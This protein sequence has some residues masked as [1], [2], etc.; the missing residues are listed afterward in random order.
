MYRF[1]GA[2][3]SLPVDRPHS[4]HV[5]SPHMS[6]S[7]SPQGRRSGEDDLA[8]SRKS[9]ELA[10]RDDVLHLWDQI[11]PREA[12]EVGRRLAPVEASTGVGDH[13]DELG[14]GWNVERGHLAIQIVSHDRRHAREATEHGGEVEARVPDGRHLDVLVVGLV[15]GVEAEE[16]EE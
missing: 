14:N 7:A 12:E 2:G 10:D 9:V 5:T 1:D 3:L 16:R 8:A 6:P 13:F 15:D 4:W 11:V